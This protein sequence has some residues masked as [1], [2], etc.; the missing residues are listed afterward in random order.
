AEVAVLRAQPHESFAST[1][2]RGD[3]DEELANRA[4][5]DHA[6]PIVVHGRSALVLDP[7]GEP[8]LAAEI[9]GEPSER[10]HETQ[11]AQGWGAEPEGDRAERLV[12]LLDEALDP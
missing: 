6:D 9:L 3:I 1:R 7:Y 2:M 11:V 5:E 10:R 4:E 8:V 12:R